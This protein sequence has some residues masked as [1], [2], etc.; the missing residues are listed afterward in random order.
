M[1][2]SKGKQTVCWSWDGAT[3][4][5]LAELDSPVFLNEDRAL[6]LRRDRVPRLVLV[7]VESERARVVDEATLGYE[8]GG[9]CPLVLPES[10]DGF[11]LSES[12]IGH[13]L[14]HW[15]KVEDDKLEISTEPGVAVL[16]VSPSGENR[17]KASGSVD[18]RIERGN[19][20]SIDVRE[21]VDAPIAR[22][23]V[24]D[25]MFLTDTEVVFRTDDFEFIGI[26]IS[27]ER[28]HWTDYSARIRDRFG[29]TEN[30]LV[31]PVARGTY[32]ALRQWGGQESYL[33]DL[34][35]ACLGE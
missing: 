3:L 30:P 32:V 18:Y 12:T 21:V 7:A 14:T 10:L 8:C 13:D 4:F 23:L 16:A 25:A 34:R 19:G 1:L 9:I 35:E 22:R 29:F 2:M 15:I 28:P 31:A 6:V 26:S 24:S 17:V 20:P 11:A 27:D 5:E 33:V